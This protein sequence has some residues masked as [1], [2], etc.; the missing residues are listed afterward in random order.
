[1]S[2]SFSDRLNGKEAE[3]NPLEMIGLSPAILRLGLDDDDLYKLCE[4]FA[5]NLAA[6]VHPDRIKK[7]TEVARGFSAALDLLKRRDVFDKAIAQFRQQDVWL[8]ANERLFVAQKTELERKLRAALENGAR[9]NKFSQWARNYLAGQSIK[10][11]SSRI[12]P[13]ALAVV[14]LCL[15][16]VPASFVPDEKGMAETQALYAD[17]AKYYNFRE[18]SLGNVRGSLRTNHLDTTT[19]GWL[20]ERAKKLGLRAPLIRWDFD[21][22]ARELGFPRAAGGRLPMLQETDLDSASYQKMLNLISDELG[23][24]RVNKLVFAPEKI[25]VPDSR[26]IKDAIDGNT[27]FLL[28]SVDLQTGFTFLKE[29]FA[30]GRAISFRPMVSSE[31][32]PSIEPFIMPG[33]ILVSILAPEPLKLRTKKADTLWKQIRE[34]RNVA[35]SQCPFFLSH[36]VL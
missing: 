5:R 23:D 1:M 9:E 12:N 24:M 31:I 3:P 13:Q 27:L 16:F 36:I 15:S 32:I 8:R 33:R 2:S 4:Q 6:K 34:R 19:I 25:T 20:I 28:G 17:A 35:M 26:F 7:E 14:S 10:I 30:G 21:V 29:G 11:S 18:P 22:A